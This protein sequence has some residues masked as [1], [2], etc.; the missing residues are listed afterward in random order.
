MT[1]VMSPVVG[2]VLRAGV[3]AD[4]SA[5]LP[6]GGR[7]PIGTAITFSKHKTGHVCL[8]VLLGVTEQQS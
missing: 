3:P 7:S 2:S 1:P 8:S 5:P 6:M 4:P